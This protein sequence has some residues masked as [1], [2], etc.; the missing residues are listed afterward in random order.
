[1]LLV[2]SDDPGSLYQLL[3]VPR[4]SLMVVIRVLVPFFRKVVFRDDENFDYRPRI[5]PSYS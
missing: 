2:S 1:M 4:P 5:A 3:L